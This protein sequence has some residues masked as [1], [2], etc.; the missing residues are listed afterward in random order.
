MAR[1]TTP[2]FD[3]AAHQDVIDWLAANYTT[4]NF[5]DSLRDQFLRKVYLSPAQVASVRTSIVRDQERAAKRAEDKAWAEA[6]AED[7]PEGKATVV[8]E[9]LTLKWQDSQFGSTLKMLVK[10]TQG[11]KVWGTVPSSLLGEDKLMAGTMVRV[12]ATFERSK[13]DP[14]F[15]FFKRPKADFAG[16]I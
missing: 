14:K 15:G 5:A 9:V 12:T 16:N 3:L 10:A 7:V 4:S 8:G 11:F 13:D 2:A 1:K 6:N